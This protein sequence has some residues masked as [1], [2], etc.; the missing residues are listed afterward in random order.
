[1]IRSTVAFADAGSGTAKPASKSCVGLPNATDLLSW[2]DLFHDLAYQVEIT[3]RIDHTRLRKILHK[4]LLKL[5]F[6]QVPW[7]Q[8]SI[9]GSD[10]NFC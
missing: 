3:V 8:N 6:M 5:L 10:C 4:P 2:K 9:D 1:M 7:S